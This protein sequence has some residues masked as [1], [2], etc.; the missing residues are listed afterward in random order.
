MSAQLRLAHLQFQAPAVDHW[1]QC[2]FVGGPRYA[3]EGE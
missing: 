1:I 2:L 3:V